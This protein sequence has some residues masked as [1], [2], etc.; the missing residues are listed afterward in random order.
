MLRKISYAQYA[1]K[2]GPRQL[3]Y[4]FYHPRNLPEDS[5]VKLIIHEVAD[6]YQ[7]RLVASNHGEPCRS[8]TGTGSILH[9]GQLLNFAGVEQFMW[10]LPLLQ[11]M[12]RCY[13]HQGSTAGEEGD[14]KSDLIFCMKVA[15]L[16]NTY[17][18]RC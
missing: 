9:H 17:E 10:L 5:L 14:G 8:P 7:I 2:D 15:D 16:N 18:M 1:N 3:P 12:D 4:G 11:I 6:C 13:N